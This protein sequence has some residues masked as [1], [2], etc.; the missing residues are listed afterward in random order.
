MSPEYLKK[1][2]LTILNYVGL[3]RTKIYS[4]IDGKNNDKYY[5]QFVLQRTRNSYICLKDERSNSRLL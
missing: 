1:L 4:L 3:N 5:P 2:T